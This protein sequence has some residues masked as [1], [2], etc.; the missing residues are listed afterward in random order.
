M[1]KLKTKIHAF[2][3]MESMVAIVI[4]MIVFSISSVVI[5]NITSSGMSREKQ[6]AYMLVK[7]LRDET[8]LTNRYFDET[9]NRNEIVVEKTIVNYG[10]SNTLKILLISAFKNKKKLFETKELILLKNEV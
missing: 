8:I 1:V 3:V 4:V 2:T 10:N 7:S 5:L 6:N 9:F